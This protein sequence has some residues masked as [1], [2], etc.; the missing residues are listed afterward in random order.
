MISWCPPTGDS[1]ESYCSGD[2]FSDTAALCESVWQDKPLHLCLRV[3]SW[4]WP[5]AAGLTHPDV[6]CTNPGHRWL[7]TPYLRWRISALIE[8]GIVT[9]PFLCPWK[10]WPVLWLLLRDEWLHSEPDHAMGGPLF[11]WLMALGCWTASRDRYWLDLTALVTAKVR[12]PPLPAETA[13]ESGGHQACWPQL[14]QL[15][16]PTAVTSVLQSKLFPAADMPL[17]EAF[18]SFHG[19]AD[20]QNC[21]Q[22]AFRQGC[23]LWTNR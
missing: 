15:R 6:V 7:I 22:Q 4:C 1:T 23:L 9:D 18:N 21:V 14:K 5:S 11:P 3:I 13:A 12:W 10:A 17:G 19:Q 20:P 16:S 8:H 2:L